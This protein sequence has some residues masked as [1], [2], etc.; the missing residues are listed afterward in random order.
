[1][2]KGDIL[3][4]SVIVGFSVLWHVLVAFQRR[5]SL[6]PYWMR[7]CTGVKWRRAF[8]DVPSESVRQFL[9]VVSDSFLLPP[10]RALQFQPS[11]RVVDVDEAQRGGNPIDNLGLSDFAERIREIYSIDLFGCLSESTTLGEVFQ[12]TLG[13]PAQPPDRGEPPDELSFRSDV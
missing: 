4:L 1:M 13:Q 8:P 10:Q 11:D 12:M 7:P 6:R 5:R 2:N 3:A 9:R